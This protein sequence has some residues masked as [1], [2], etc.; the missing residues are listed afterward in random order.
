MERYR[1]GYDMTVLW[2]INDRNGAAVPLGDKDVHLYYTCERGRYEVPFEIQDDNVIVWH[3]YGKDQRALGTYTLTIEVFQSNGKRT[4]RRDICA[5]FALVG[6]NCEECYDNGEAH[7]NEGGTL[8]L[9]TEL[10]IYRIQPVI[11]YIVEDEKGIGYWWVDG[12]N[13]GIRASGKSAYEIAVEIGGFEGTEEEFGRYLAQVANAISEI[14]ELKRSKFGYSRVK[15]N[16]EQYFAD[17]ESAELYDSNP[18]A[19]SSFLLHEIDLPAGGGG[20]S[21][22]TSIDPELLEAYMPMSR[23]F[24]DDFNNDF[25]R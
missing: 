23:D 24:S 20:S 19:N 4:I 21:G 25:A 7:I 2:S 14:D 17:Q 8:T 22:G 16:K 6:R 13:T 15:N 5:A 12:V 3:F 10:D 9:A 1:I 18:I 11:P